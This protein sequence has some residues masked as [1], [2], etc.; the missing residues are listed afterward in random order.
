MTQIRTASTRETPSK[1]KTGVFDPVAYTRNA[2]NKHRTTSRWSAVGDT[3]QALLGAA[4]ILMYA[5]SLF[6]GIQQDFVV[7]SGWFLTR[8]LTSENFARVPA[9]VAIDLLLILAVAYGLLIAC[10]TGPVSASRAQGYWWLSLPVDRRKLVIGPLAKKIAWTG[11][12]A[13]LVMAPVV[14]L[15]GPANGLPSVILACLTAV[16]LGAVILTAA[17]VVQLGGVQRIVERYIRALSGIV[18]VLLLLPILLPQTD[19]F[20]KALTT[21]LPALPSSWPLLVA[22]GSFWPLFVMF[23]LALLGTIAVYTRL[24]RLRRAELVAARGV[25]GHASSAIYFGDFRELGQA[26]RTSSGARKRFSI[27]KRV[28]KSAAGVLVL[29]DL[30][31]FLRKPQTVGTLLG[32]AVL[33]GAIALIE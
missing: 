13:G 31:A 25:T 27:T 9:A 18:L 12:V 3:Y 33:P 14:A 32:L 15:S 23:A 11:C 2:F 8:S 1:G 28:P 10:R 7:D 26:L 19:G 6:Y 17:V 5:G 24:G 16:F 21:I 29:A 4:I 20:F 22:R 30:V